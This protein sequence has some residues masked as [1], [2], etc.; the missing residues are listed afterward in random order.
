MRTW[1]EC[2]GICCFARGASGSSFDSGG[3]R[4]GRAR[5]EA[6]RLIDRRVEA[7]LPE[8]AAA[9]RI[10]QAGLED[11]A[12]VH[13]TDGASDQRVNVQLAGNVR[14]RLISVPVLHRRRVRDDA[15]GS[16][17]SEPAG[18]RLR[19]ALGEVVGVAAARLEWKH[20]E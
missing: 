18:Q 3:D 20:C 9:A 15:S 17:A 6:G 12:A 8:H 16:G 14:Q 11:H 10:H 7:I 2:A 5:F 19:D 13:S 1:I 4:V